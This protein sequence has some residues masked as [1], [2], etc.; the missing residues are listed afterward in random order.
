MR[1]AILMQFKKAQ[2]KMQSILDHLLVCHA[3]GAYAFHPDP[4]QAI[5]YAREV[6]ADIDAELAKVTL[7]VAA[8]KRAAFKR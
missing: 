8:R 1:G 4:S 6:L 5:S 7:K 3:A 2:P